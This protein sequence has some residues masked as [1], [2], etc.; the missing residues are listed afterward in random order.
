MKLTDEQRETLELM[1]STW[2]TKR[3]MALAVGI[4][5]ESFEDEVRDETSDI[6]ETVNRSRILSKSKV[7]KSVFDMAAAGS[8]VAQQIALKIIEKEEIEN[9]LNT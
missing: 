3:E 6:Y 8:S 1:A 7:L 9:E 5:C 4:S 2:A